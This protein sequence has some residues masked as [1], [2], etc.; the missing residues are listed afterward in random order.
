MKNTNSIHETIT[1]NYGDDDTNTQLNFPF[2]LKNNSVC[3]LEVTA[4]IKG[5]RK[6]C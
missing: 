6:T 4:L 2:T 5:G 3:N 1:K